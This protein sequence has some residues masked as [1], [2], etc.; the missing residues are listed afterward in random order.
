MTLLF[1]LFVVLFASA[2]HDKT[3]I[4]R[5]SSAVK[6]GFWELGYFSGSNS[7]VDVLSSDKSRVGSVL[8]P[9]EIEA[10][11]STLAGNPGIN[12]LELQ[13]KLNQALGKEI[14]RQE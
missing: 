3:A 8:S 10:R 7:A 11:P 2:Q 13:K 5:V 14:E 6:S 9:K 1:A 12:V 4:R